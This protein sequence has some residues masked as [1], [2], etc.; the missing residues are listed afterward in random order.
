M[1][2]PDDLESMASKSSSSLTGVRNLTDLVRDHLKITVL[3]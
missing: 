1:N 2:I 3:L